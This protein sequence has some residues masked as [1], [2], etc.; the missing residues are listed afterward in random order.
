MG[1]SVSSYLIA[2][3][4]TVLVEMGVGVAWGL[5]RWPEI[6]CVFWVNVF[7]HPL[8]CF[9]IATIERLQSTPIEFAETIALELAV[10]LLE[11][12]LMCYALPRRRS[13]SLL[14]LSMT[15]NG[16]SYGTGLILALR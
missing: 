13:L 14:A 10:T 12:T 8:L 1:T 6:A 4:L 9:A 11:W 5:R 7:T 3:V 15:M 16:L 2:F